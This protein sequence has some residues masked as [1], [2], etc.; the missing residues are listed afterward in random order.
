[1]R[2]RRAGEGAQKCSW[3]AV[4]KGAS[5]FLGVEFVGTVAHVA[6]APAEG[7]DVAKAKVLR[8]AIWRWKEGKEVF[9]LVYG[10]CSFPHP[11]S[12]LLKDCSAHRARTPS[13]SCRPRR[14]SSRSRHPSRSWTPR[15]SKKSGSQV[16]MACPPGRLRCLTH[17]CSVPGA[18]CVR[19]AE[20]GR[21]RPHPRGRVRR[22]DRRDPTRSALRRVRVS[23]SH[24]LRQR[25][26]A[27][28]ATVTA[29]TSSQD[30][31]ELATSGRP[32]ARRR[33]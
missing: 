10:V 27:R 28:R 7:D 6:P 17:T 24:P 20:S 32:R 16:R 12:T 3:R 23:R 1:V 31:L 2:A 29:T 8:A 9:G 18:D 21:A 4:P 26:M 22:R 30:K 14:T 25:L 19:R 5:G 11:F 13:K 15:A 33:A